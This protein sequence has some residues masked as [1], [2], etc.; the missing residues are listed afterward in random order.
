MIVSFLAMNLIYW[1]PNMPAW[2]DE[3]MKLFGGEVFWPWFTLI[4]TTLTLG[5]A[6]IVKAV[7]PEKTGTG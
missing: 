2:R 7:W 3:W 5:T 4:G 6:W 1:P